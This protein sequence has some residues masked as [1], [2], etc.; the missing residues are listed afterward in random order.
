MYI[1]DTSDVPATIFEALRGEFLSYGLTDFTF[2]TTPDLYIVRAATDWMAS[3]TVQLTEYFTAIHTD[4]AFI[5]NSMRSEVLLPAFEIEF[6][7]TGRAGE[8]GSPNFLTTEEKDIVENHRSQG[9]ILVFKRDRF[10]Q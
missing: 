3:D 7:T 4:P 2:E 1:G 6:F 9:R 8:F 10:R 5:P